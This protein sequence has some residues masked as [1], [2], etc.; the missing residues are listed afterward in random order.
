M[1]CD[2]PKGSRIVEQPVDAVLVDVHL[3]AP[4]DGFE[5]SQMLTTPRPRPDD[6]AH[7]RSGGRAAAG[8][9]RGE[10]GPASTRSGCASARCWPGGGGDRGGRT[11]LAASP[12]RSARRGE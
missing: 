12:A 10:R 7:E 4:V 2:F 6:R 9:P 11:A 5:V 1:G 8:V 3:G